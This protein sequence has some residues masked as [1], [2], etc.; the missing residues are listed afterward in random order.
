M[1]ANGANPQTCFMNRCSQNTFRLTV[2]YICI[3]IY[4]CVCV[5]VCV[6]LRIECSAA[7][8]KVCVVPKR[9]ATS[10]QEVRGYISVMA[11]FKFAYFLIK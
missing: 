10:S 1:T 3:C 8:P 4:V 2:I 5:C 11:A 9:S 6:S 7:V